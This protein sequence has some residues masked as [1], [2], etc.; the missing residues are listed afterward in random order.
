MAFCM[1]ALQLRAAAPRAAPAAASFKGDARP[2]AA[3]AA[4]PLRAARLTIVAAEAPAAPAAP[5]VFVPPVLDPNTPSPI[6]GGS[7]GGLLRKA[8]VRNAQKAAFRRRPDSARLARRR[9]AA[10]APASAPP[11]AAWLR[12]ARRGR[13]ARAAAPVRLAARSFCST[14]FVRSGPARRRW[15]SSTSSPGR[16]RRSRSSRCRCAPGRSAARARASRPA[17]KS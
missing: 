15:R 1:N 9:W 12:A 10:A 16:R 2:L 17:R 6:F 4:A 5:A 8:Q 11:R 3:R 13:A 14:D 7:T